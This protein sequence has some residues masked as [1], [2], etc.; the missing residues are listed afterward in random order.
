MKALAVQ[1]LMLPYKAGNQAEELSPENLEKV[2][3]MLDQVT[4]SNVPRSALIQDISTVTSKILS[5]SS[6]K[7]NCNLKKDFYLY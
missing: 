6:I 4:I 5:K 1:E 7:A 3:E 2:S